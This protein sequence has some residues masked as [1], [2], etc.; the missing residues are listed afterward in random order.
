MAV[1]KKEGRVPSMSA[2]SFGRAAPPGSIRNAREEVASIGLMAAQVVIASRRVLA[3]LPLDDS[4]K[5][6][7]RQVSK[8]MR[9]EADA[10]QFVNTSGEEG[11]APSRLAASEIG[12]EV[13]LSEHGVGQPERVVKALKDIAKNLNRLA[14]TPSSELAEEI[15]RVFSH[16]A[17][18]SRSASGSSGDQL[19]GSES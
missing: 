7:L 8:F 19:T 12:P 2:G 14:R 9:E 15:F 16:L 1:K 3:G 6:T 4:D 13:I 18:Y 11:K 17:G 5:R 10:I